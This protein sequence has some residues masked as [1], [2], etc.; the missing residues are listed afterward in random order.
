VLQDIENEG[1]IIDESKLQTTID[2]VY[3]DW[4]IEN[5]KKFDIQYSYLTEA[6]QILSP[7]KKNKNSEEDF[8][9]QFDG[10]KILPQANKSLFEKYLSELD[11]INAESQKVQIKKGRFAQWIH[12]QISSKTYLLLLI[13]IKCWNNDIGSPIKSTTQI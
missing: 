6:M 1:G 13:K 2:K 11:F 3:P 10:I 8:Y 12:S 5:K 9:K 7:L 4:N